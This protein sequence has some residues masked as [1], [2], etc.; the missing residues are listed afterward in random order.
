MTKNL[1][2]YYD[3]GDWIKKIYVVSVRLDPSLSA[4]LSR[5]TG[6]SDD[7]PSK[8]TCHDLTQC[9]LRRSFSSSVGD[10]NP[11]TYERPLGTTNYSINARQMVSFGRQRA[12]DLPFH[13]DVAPLCGGSRHQSKTA[14]AASVA[15][16]LAYVD[17]IGFNSS[18]VR[19]GKPDR[20]IRTSLH[21]LS[22]QYLSPGLAKV[23]HLSRDVRRLSR[24]HALEDSDGLQ[25]PGVFAYEGACSQTLDRVDAAKRQ[26]MRNAE[27]FGCRGPA[28]AY[29]TRDTPV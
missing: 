21:D 12:S 2:D 3:D 24:S 14:A 6:Q 17:C 26:L 18:F 10:G 19:S 20:C 8:T 27:T 4:S 7:D 11:S 5:S 9:P 25:S 15:K 22:S 1:E 28:E 16:D 23:T 29:D 13:A